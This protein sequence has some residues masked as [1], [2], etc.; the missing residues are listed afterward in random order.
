MAIDI[1]SLNI[2]EATLIRSSNVQSPT[3][4]KIDELKAKLQKA[5]E[6]GEVKDL[7][8]LS[9]TGQE[10]AATVAKT[11]NVRKTDYAVD[12]F[13]RKDMPKIQNEDGTYSVGGVS[14]SKE[15]LENARTVMMSAGEEISAGSG[16]NSTLDYNNYA[17]M[18]IAETAV[19]Q[20]AKENF[21]EEQQKVIAKAMKEYNAGLEELQNKTLSDMN[22]VDN[23]YG[24]ISYYYG[25]SNVLDE[26]MADML[27]KMKEELSRLTGRQYRKSVAG[28]VAGTIQTAT[29]T[30]LI[31]NI[32]SVFADVDLNDEKSVSDAMKKYQELV[33]PAYMANGNSSQSVSRIL[34]SDTDRFMQMIENIKRS[35]AYKHIEVSV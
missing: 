14:F 20:Y 24:E 27:N 5:K 29:N 31:N 33:R 4:V 19:D 30:K 16:K 7:L 6:N 13:F 21:N 9:S 26:N 1:L 17:Q 32:K 18:A 34:N 8:Q 12:A 15:E 10:K 25:K 2:P 23:N 11:D 22:A 3:R 28:E 35:Q